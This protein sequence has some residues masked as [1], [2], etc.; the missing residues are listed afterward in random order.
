MGLDRDWFLGHVFAP[1]CSTLQIFHNFA[2]I[3]LIVS[4]EATRFERS[5]NRVRVTSIL[6]GQVAFLLRAEIALKSRAKS[7]AMDF[8]L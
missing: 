8:T 3:F 4:S 2:R 7:R 6:N 5:E 1:G